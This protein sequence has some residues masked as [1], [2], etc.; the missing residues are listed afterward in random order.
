MLMAEDAPRSFTHTL[1]GSL[2]GIDRTE[3]QSPI[4]LSN[5]TKA[6]LQR[7]LNEPATD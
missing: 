5:E 3:C 4:S 6:V 1:A 7:L 2:L